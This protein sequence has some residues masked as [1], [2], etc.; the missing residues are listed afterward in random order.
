[1]AVRLKD[2]ALHAGVSVK[3]VSN[4]VNDQ[5]HVSPGM[6]ERVSA[7]LTALGYRPNLAARQLKHGRGGFIALAL[8]QLTQPYFAEV[9]ARLSEQATRR[10]FLLLLDETG[11]D[12]EQERLV[13]SGIRAHMVDGVILSPLTLTAEEIAA[14]TDSLPLVLLGERR[15]P[16]QF[17]HVAVDSVAASRAM[18]EHLLGTGRRRLAALGRQLREGTASVR[19][20]GYRE[21][22]DAA[23]VELPAERVVR[24]RGFGRAE[25]YLG[26][27]ALLD[28]PAAHRPDAVFAFNDLMAVGALRACFEAGVRV[29]DDIAVAGFDDIPEGRFHTPALTTIRPDLDA[30]TRNVLDLL[31]DRINGST[32]QPAHPDV[33]WSLLPR[34]STTGT[35]HPVVVLEETA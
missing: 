10:G 8:P 15:T 31:I 28:L 35:R 26:M 33:P 9:A 6:R 3:T 13:L 27:R 2:V 34:E 11:G 23:G 20:R 24:V 12:P 4:V 21:A 16:T 32:A 22:L 30:L 19:L 14:R 29:P 5:P 7:S 1:M 25:G 17:D 18:G